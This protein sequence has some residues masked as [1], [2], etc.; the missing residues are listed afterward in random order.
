MEG[1]N[2]TVLSPDIGMFSFI[3][4]YKYECVMVIRLKKQA[5]YQE[6]IFR[7]CYIRFG[8]SNLMLDL[9]RHFIHLK[10]SVFDFQMNE[11]GP[12]MGH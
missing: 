7:N 6:F 5:L 1:V 2:E 11:V 3:R 4:R 12:K 8:I 10:E 9:G